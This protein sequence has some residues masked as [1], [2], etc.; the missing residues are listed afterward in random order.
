[1]EGGVL[2]LYLAFDDKTHIATTIYLLNQ[3]AYAR[4]FQ[5][6]EQYQ[7]LRDTFLKTYLACIRMNQQLQALVEKK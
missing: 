7:Q 3:E 6:I 4:K 2:G 1:L 5:T